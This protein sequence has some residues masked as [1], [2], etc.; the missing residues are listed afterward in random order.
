MSFSCLLNI[1]IQIH[2]LSHSQVEVKGSFTRK[3]EILSVFRAPALIS[4][5]HHWRPSFSCRTRR[6]RERERECK[7]LH[8]NAAAHPAAPDCYRHLCRAFYFG[9]V[10]KSRSRSKTLGSCKN[11]SRK[12]GHAHSTAAFPIPRSSLLNYWID[13]KYM[14]LQTDRLCFVWQ[15]NYHVTS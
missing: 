13:S 4:V 11:R 9:R 7:N 15:Q 1:L 3:G 2:S 14:N 6:G 5:S 12:W 10:Q 8:H